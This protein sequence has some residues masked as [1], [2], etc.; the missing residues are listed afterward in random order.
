MYPEDCRNCEGPNAKLD[1]IFRH[2][3]LKGDLS[4]EQIE[5][6]MVIA[7]KCPVHKTL[8]AGITIKSTKTL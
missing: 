1:H 8:S 5:R 3:C 7:D 2:I 6:L 4:E